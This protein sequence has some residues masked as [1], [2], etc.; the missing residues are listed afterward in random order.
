METKRRMSVV[1]FVKELFRRFNDDDIIG[2]SAELAYF[3]L[4]S[5]FPFL[6]FLVTLLAY[7]PVSQE[8]V[9]EVFQQFAPGETLEMIEANLKLIVGSQ[10]STLLSFGIIGT[11]WTASIG[12]NAVVRAFNR[13]YEVNESRSPLVARGVSI[14]LT[15]A[16]IFVIVV[17]LLLPV[18]GQKIG[19]FISSSFGFSIE[20]MNA[21]NAVRWIL[22]SI[23][24]LVVFSFLYFIAPNKRLKMKE[25]TTGA[26]F[27][28][29]GWIIVSVAFSYYVESFGNYSS[30][31]G[32]LG[33]IIVLMIWFYL[34]GMTI[35]VGG[36]INAIINCRRIDCDE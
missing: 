29:V 25:V 5:L 7:L 24:L 31:Y 33:G 12:M 16:M 28:T 19:L 34:T 6:I 35:I 22:S 18:F 36:E 13:A 8:D 27:A 26:I 1:F 20:F 10:N 17:A 11:I 30:T 14:L 2:L 9:M 4:L 23:I 3:F 15:F 32:S 21:W